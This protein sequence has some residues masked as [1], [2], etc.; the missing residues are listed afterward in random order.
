MIEISPE[1]VTVIMLGGILV[2]VFSGYPLAVV[3]GGI[4]FIVGYLLLGASVADL[5]YARIYSLIHNYVLLALPLF[6]F[7]GVMLERSGMAARLY[8]VLY[9]WLGGFR[10]GLAIVTI[11]MGTIIAACV[12]VVGASVT[13]LTLVALPSM[14]KRGYSKS[15][16]TASVCA[17]G[18]LGTLIPPSV[19]LVIYGPMAGI[20]V[21]KLFMGA[22]F[23]GL[24][25]SGLYCTYIAIR[26]FFQPAIAPAVPPEE[27]R[28]SFI[29]KTYMLVTSLVPPAFIILSVLG[30]IFMGLAPPTEAA[31]VGAFAATLLAVV[32]RKLNW[33]VLKETAM[34]T[35]WITSMILLIGATAAAFV[36]VFLGAGGGEVVENFIL[37]APFGRWGAFGMVMFIIFILGFFIDWMAILF[38]LVPIVAPTA[39][40]LG[41]DPLW[42][43]MMIIVNFQMAYMTPPFAWPM[44]Y[45]RGVAP[46]EL[47]VTIGDII[48]GVIPF[49]FL[50]M[51]ALGLCI[52]F[53]QIILW[54]PGKMIR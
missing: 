45:V 51:I 25:L 48:R 21:G 38:I 37:T 23:P 34:Q 2:G 3:I 19:M 26:S 18:S 12:G 14:I 52:V 46:P 44:F 7:M 10:G 29:R 30:A 54:L 15:L 6:V 42:F 8:D 13:M 28:V 4:G 35:L 5:M 24:V 16:A 27:R 49:V 11:I 32:Y 47:G 20:S 43:G 9:I 53:P 33:Q 50:I 31:A 40:A 1:L 22:I 17:G 41:F 39:S 36:G